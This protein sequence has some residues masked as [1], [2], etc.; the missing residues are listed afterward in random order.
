MNEIT[1]LMQRNKELCLWLS[2]GD[3]VS[4]SYGIVGNAAMTRNSVVPI[5][6]AKQQIQSHIEHEWEVI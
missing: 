3:M 1:L 2:C 5:E 6:I 4:C